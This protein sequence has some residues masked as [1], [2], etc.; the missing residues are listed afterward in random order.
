MKIKYALLLLAVLL[1]VQCKTTGL[2]QIKRDIN[3]SYSIKSS[4]KG[5][6]GQSRALMFKTLPADIMRNDTIIIIEYY[7][8]DNLN[9]FVSLYQ[10]EDKTIECHRIVF[11]R[12]SEKQITYSLVPT[13]FP[14]KIMEMVIRGDIEEVKRRGDNRDWTPVTTLIIN[15]GVKD[16]KKE[17]FNFTTIIANNFHL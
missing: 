15:I 16:Q 12:Y 7:T 3:N 10:S 17:K 8:S 11:N 14:D 4:N 1:F 2:T 6:F 13:D 9:Y 5:A